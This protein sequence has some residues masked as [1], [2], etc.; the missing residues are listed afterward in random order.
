MED[1]M[2]NDI[3][4]WI[5]DIRN[6]SRMDEIRWGREPGLESQ[7]ALDVEEWLKLRKELFDQVWVR[8]IITHPPEEDAVPKICLRTQGDMVKKAFAP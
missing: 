3:S 4:L 5:E 7:K 2:D 1:I 8:G 6:T